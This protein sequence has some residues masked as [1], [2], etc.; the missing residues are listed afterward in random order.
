MGAQ[1]V[2][3]PLC[4]VDRLKA[5]LTAE[6]ARREEAE[7]VGDH[8]NCPH[9]IIDDH[10]SAACFAAGHC[11]C[12]HGDQYRLTAAEAT[13]AS[14][15]AALKKIAAEPHWSRLDAGE[16]VATMERYAREALASAPEP[17][18]PDAGEQFAEN[19]NQASPS[20]RTI[21]E[22]LAGALE[23]F[24]ARADHYEGRPDSKGVEIFPTVGE[25]RAAR[26]ALARYRAI[27]E[28]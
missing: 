8:R 20:L 14:L 23:P 25:L 2:T 13:I 26:E 17:T 16:I 9:P 1:G 15:R 3:D 18:A 19:A 5:A 22:E 6:T 4:E 7:R 12:V 21:A 24:A 28:E 10:S 27:G 11:G